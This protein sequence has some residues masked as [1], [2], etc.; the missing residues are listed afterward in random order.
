MNANEGNAGE[1]AQLRAEVARLRAENGALRAR[2][3]QLCLSDL[4]FRRLLD[5]EIIGVLIGA[6]SGEILEVNPVF[7]THHR[8]FERAVEF[9]A[10]A[11]LCDARSARTASRKRGVALGKWFVRG[12]GNRIFATRRF[13]RA[14]PY[15]R[16]PD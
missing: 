8:A 3:E 15:R 4:R 16:D 12:V 2:N 11:K 5:S 9:I 7:R 1:L 13:A 10:L 6:A 14:H